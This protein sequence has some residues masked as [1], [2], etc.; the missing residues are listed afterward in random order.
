MRWRR[1][2]TGFAWCPFREFAGLR[3]SL[4]PSGRAYKISGLGDRSLTRE[5]LADVDRGTLVDEVLSL[6]ER[7][8][9][10]RAEGDDCIRIEGSEGGTRHLRVRPADHRQLAGR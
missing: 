7:N 2:T 1:R 4:C 5:L 8:V 3:L 6:E 10:A 9:L